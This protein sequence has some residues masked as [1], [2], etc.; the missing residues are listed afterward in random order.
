MDRLARAATSERLVRGAKMA[1]GIGTVGADS[2]TQRDL[3]AHALAETAAQRGD[4]EE[5]DRVEE[6]E[7][8]GRLVNGTQSVS[9]RLVRSA[10]VD[11]GGE[12]ALGERE[13]RIDEH[14]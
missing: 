7:R 6:R 2:L 3:G 1:R 12:H 11:R 14:E 13:L 4:D 8:P 5:D 9:Q 10:S